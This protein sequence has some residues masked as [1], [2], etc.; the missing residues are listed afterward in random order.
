MLNNSASPSVS[1]SHY[2]KKLILMGATLAFAG[3][4]IAPSNAQTQS[5][6]STTST[7][8]IQSS[9]IIGSKIRSSDGA[10]L[11]VIKDVVLDRS[12]GCMAYTVL[13]TTGANNVA[14]SGGSKS[15]TTTTTH[16]TVA[17]PWTAYTA[18]SDPTVYTTTVQRERIYNA[19]V[20]DYTHVQEYSR[21]DY[22]S[23]IYSYY[24]VQPGVGISA[25]INVGGSRDGNTRSGY[26]ASTNAT[27]APTGT[28]SPGA[29][30]AP[31]ATATATV[32]P[33]PSYSPTPLGTATPAAAAATSTP[34]TSASASSADENAKS[35]ATP[36]TSAKG[37]SSPTHK[38]SSSSKSESET[39]T[40][41]SE[42]SSSEAK[43]SGTSS[44]PKNAAN[45]EDRTSSKSKRE[46]T[47]SKSKSDAAEESA[48]PEPSQ[49]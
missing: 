47:S 15:T 31:T 29:T 46:K 27:A 22:I 25:N 38:R 23:G 17:V 48:S 9:K 35:S 6:T 12:T 3:L 14:S 30:A 34:R 39:A 20:Y 24:G 42:S 11:G 1:L 4:A 41:S 37:S 49:P 32:S 18:T 10:E 8:Y 2:M 43:G 26:G 19:P 13:E 21:P 7:G 44:S 5:T 40:P 33:A 36:K 16:K 28:A 45:D